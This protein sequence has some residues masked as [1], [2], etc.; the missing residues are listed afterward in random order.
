MRHRHEWRL[1]DYE[2]A[3]KIGHFTTGTEQI[4]LFIERGEEC[5]SYSPCF[6]SR[7]P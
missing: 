2:W 6:H 3:E 7:R 4:P 1:S 5:S